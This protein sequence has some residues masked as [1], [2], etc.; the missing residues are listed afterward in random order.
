MV[1]TIVGLGI[2]LDAIFLSVLVYIRSDVLRVN[3]F[4]DQRG[5]VII[6]GIAFFFV[7]GGILTISGLRG[8]RRY[9]S[10]LREAISMLI[11]KRLI[12]VPGLSRSLHLSAA[13]VMQDIEKAKMD[14]YLPAGVEIRQPGSLPL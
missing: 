8:I 11:E 4:G 10:V 13:E 12:D 3:V 2:I 6:G 1:M 9:K 14:G 5:F 7:L